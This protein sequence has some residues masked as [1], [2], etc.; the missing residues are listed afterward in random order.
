MNEEYRVRFWICPGVV[1]GK[2]GFPG[3][4]E[5]FVWKVYRINSRESL[6]LHILQI[7]KLLFFKFGFEAAA[8]L[9][10]AMSGEGSP[11]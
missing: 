9:Q 10:Q 3:R 7:S 2:G 1:L 11:S 5:K 8:L 6:A 4:P